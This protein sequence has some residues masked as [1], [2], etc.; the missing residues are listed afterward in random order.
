VARNIPVHKLQERSALGLELGHTSLPGAR[1]YLETV[2]IHRDDCYSFLLVE[3]GEGSMDV[4]FVNIQ[5]PTAHVYYLLPG[6]IHHNIK[7]NK[8]NAWYI[9]VN[10]SLIPKNYRQVFEGNLSMQ[11]PLGLN[12]M[13]FK[14]FKNIIYLLNDQFNGDKN[15]TF[16]T[17]LVHSLL[18]SLLG[19]YAKI[20][21]R[22]DTPNKKSSRIFQITQQFKKLLTEKVQIEKSPSFYASELNISE[23]YLNE[24]VK[25]ITG[26]TVTYW[27]M[28]EIM[29]EAKRLLIYTQLSIKEISYQL[30]YDDHTYFSRLFK[31]QNNYT[32]TGFREDYLK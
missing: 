7:T 32:P 6:Q 12:A 2:D 13:A 1:E 30:G 3:K 22:K 21:Q 14:Q 9:S 27:L 25:E 18:D 24:A 5:L 8:A 19:M 16:Y 28:N 4:D 11:Q 20:Y 10:T 23:T 29:I 26:F 17:Q 15:S 31:K